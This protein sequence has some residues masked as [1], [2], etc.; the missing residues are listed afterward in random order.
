MS[1]L[2]R[3]RN[4]TNELILQYAIENLEYIIES[5]IVIKNLDIMESL[6][7]SI[8]VS[9]NQRK[10]LLALWMPEISNEMITY[11]LFNLK[12]KEFFE[13]CGGKRPSLA[14]TEVNEKLLK[15]ML[16]RG[17]ISSYK[18]DSQKK[19]MLKVYSK[20]NV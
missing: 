3:T 18:E 4:S 2:Y 15:A 17:L 11:Y 1:L 7:F 5:K 16:K 12:E 14:K 13:A 8:R 6:W 9:D 19:E 10:E 20:K